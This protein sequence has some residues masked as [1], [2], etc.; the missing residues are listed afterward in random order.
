M[1]NWEKPP[2]DPYAQWKVYN[3]RSSALTIN[4]QYRQ[5]RA[6]M[7]ENHQPT[8]RPISQILGLKTKPG[9]ALPPLTEDDLHD[10]TVKQ[11]LT[12]TA[13]MR[14]ECAHWRERAETAESELLTREHE[15]KATDVQLRG[16]ISLLQ[17]QLADVGHKLE[18]FHK[19]ALEM[20]TKVNDIEMFYISELG[21]LSEHVNQAANS[22]ISFAN[23]SI[24]SLKTYIDD[25]HAK[26]K[27]AEY[28]KTGL[29][30]LG[31]T[32]S[33]QEDAE[34]TELAAKFAPRQDNE[35]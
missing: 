16:K 10:E 8:V 32:S 1:M 33:P 13:R 2:I 4:R 26:A 31:E 24:K 34:L 14:Q 20:T 28:T 35:Y 9:K 17:E 3:E 19:R 25:M 11:A 29:P 5:W 30:A 15:H 22:I 21:R 6:N 18:H 7:G 23:G 27:H 12:I